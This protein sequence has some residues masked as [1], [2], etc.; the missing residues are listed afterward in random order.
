VRTGTVVAICGPTR[1]GKDLLRFMRTVAA[2][3][4]AGPVLLGQ[5]Q[6][7]LRRPHAAL[8]AIQPS[9]RRA[10]RVSRHAEHASWVN[11]IELFFSIV[12]R[13]RLRQG[14]FR[15]VAELRTA[16]LRFIEDGNRH[17][18]D[19]FRWSFAGD[20]LQAEPRARSA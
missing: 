13:Q 14:D 15:S 16:L 17:R 4:P 10:L 6:Y 3:Y 11:Q 18:A 9:P 12:H 2:Q 7:P 20:P 1:K 19:P 5:P 8:V